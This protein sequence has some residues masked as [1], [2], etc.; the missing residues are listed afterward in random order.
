[1][2]KGLPGKLGKS[3]HL[4]PFFPH[5]CLD[6]ELHISGIKQNSTAQTFIL[7]HQNN[8]DTFNITQNMKFSAE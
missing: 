8:T 4:L 7:S 3:Y 2:F 6:K 1:M 5:V